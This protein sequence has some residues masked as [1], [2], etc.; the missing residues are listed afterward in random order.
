VLQTELA[1]LWRVGPAVIVQAL[2][3]G[4][5]HWQGFP[6]GW[7]GVL[8]STGYGLMLGV[9]RCRAVGILAVV[10]VQ[11]SPTPPSACSAFITCEVS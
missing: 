1:R 4:V 9:I 6:S 5:A 10:V 3:F 2:A 7:L 11:S 8:M